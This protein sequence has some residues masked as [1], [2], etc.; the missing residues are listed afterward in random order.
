MPDAIQKHCQ[1]IT[2][3]TPSRGQ[4]KESPHVTVAGNVMK[5]SLFMKKYETLNH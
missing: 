4:N 2:V 1:S 3:P 5:A